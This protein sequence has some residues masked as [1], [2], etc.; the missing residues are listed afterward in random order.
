VLS[1][2]GQVGGEQSFGQWPA[3]LFVL[4]EGTSNCGTTSSASLN[5]NYRP[6][7]PPPAPRKTPADFG[8]ATT[9]A[10]PHPA[11]TRLDEASGDRRGRLAQPRLGT[12]Q[13]V[14]GAV[15]P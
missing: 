4:V 11:L 1:G 15:L 10:D 2:D 7:P 14:L 6:R 5:L 12:R 8:A 3:G 9:N 13:P